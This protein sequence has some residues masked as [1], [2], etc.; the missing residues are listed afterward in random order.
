MNSSEALSTFQSTL[1]FVCEL[2]KKKVKQYRAEL[3]K[4]PEGALYINKSNGNTYFEY[5]LN[6]CRRGATQDQELIYRLARKKYLQLKIQSYE[7]HFCMSGRAL[8]MNSNSIDIRIRK[9]L[10][11]YGD[12]GLDVMRITCSKEQY[13][14]AHADYKRNTM[15]EETRIYSTYSGVRVRSKSE[16]KIGNELELNGIPYRYEQLLSVYIGWMEGVIGGSID[17][18]KDYYP[19]FTIRTA[20]GEYIIWE[21][22]GRVDLADYR[23]RNAEKISAFRQGTGISDE[24]F[25]LSFE[26][27]L[28][29]AGALQQLIARRILPYM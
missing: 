28:Q 17:N 11:R 8:K 23:T 6:G 10:V 14:W 1:A 13:Q 26:K 21:H 18:H 16:Q 9:L 4:L 5:A 2:E 24:L 19:D 3:Q 15:K 22:L 12:A 27:D 20:T 7:N 25:I 29:E